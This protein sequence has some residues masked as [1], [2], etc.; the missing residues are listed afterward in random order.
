MRVALLLALAGAAR[1]DDEVE[2]DAP[3][4]PVVAGV[5]WKGV[6][7]VREADLEDRILTAHRPWW[8]PWEKRPTFD[9]AALEGDVARIQAAY[10]AH[11]YYETKVGY[12]VEWSDDRSSARVVF[13]V[14]EGE[15]VRLEPPRIVFA[16]GSELDEGRRDALLADLPLD[17]GEPFGTEDYRD[18]RDELLRRLANA[19]HPDAR[20]EGGARIDVA[21]LAAWID[22]EIHPGPL[23]HFG[24][25]SVAGLDRVAEATVLRELVFEEGDVYSLDAVEESQRQVYGLDLFRSVAIRARR[26]AQNGDAVPEEATWPVEIRVE[27]TNPRTFRVGVGYG[28]EDQFRGEVKWLHRNFFGGA[29]TLQLTARYSSLVAGGEAE[30]VQPRLPD[31]LLS[32]SIRASAFRETLP[33]F[34]ANRAAW[35]LTF[36]RPLFERVTGTLGY[37]FDYGD[38]TRVKTDDLGDVEKGSRLSLLQLGLERVVVDDSLDPTRGTRLNLRVEPSLRGIG[39]QVDYVKLSTE[40]RVYLPVWF[41]VLGL[42]LKLATVQPFGSSD[43]GDVPIFKRLFSGGSTSVRGFDYQ[44]LGPLDANGDPLG[45]LS[46]VEANAE[47]RIPIWRFVG[48]VAFLDSGQISSGP[49]RFRFDDL[50]YSTGAG[51]RVKTPFGSIGVDYGYI[52]NP[53]DLVDRS[54][55]HFSVGHTF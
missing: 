8:K 46:L 2:P 23:V 15:P 25:A 48:A 3:R 40:G 12:A 32:L 54:R 10:R 31:P 44:Q 16:N 14:N 53:P 52:L 26:P 24:P 34:D 37:Q 36:R 21:R 22:W 47:L 35:G 7:H 5:D 42:R 45:G 9:E 29:R 11:G 4:L 28:T 43:R 20:L 33:A 55:I 41:T 39:S 17:P 18:A 50:F 13:R 30:F 1:A 19:G 38:V 51:L 6:D 27:E 49:M